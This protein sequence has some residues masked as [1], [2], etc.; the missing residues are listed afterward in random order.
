M[1][2]HEG[3]EGRLWTEQDITTA[4][5][6]QCNYYSPHMY[7]VCP[8]IFSSCPSLYQMMKNNFEAILCEYAGLPKYIFF[9]FSVVYVIKDGSGTWVY[10]FPLVVMHQLSV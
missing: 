9:R 3:N 6:S 1:S 8:F 7:N 4:F 5:T 2:V 10:V